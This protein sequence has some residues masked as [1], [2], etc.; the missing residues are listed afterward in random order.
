M[1]RYRATTFYI[2]DLFN[3]PVHEKESI[4]RRAVYYIRA[5]HAF[6][7]RVSMRFFRKDASVE[8]SKGNIDIGIPVSQY[9]MAETLMGFTGIVFDVMEH[10]LG[11]DSIDNKDK[12]K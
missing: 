3:Y 12:E 4:G 9:D 1:K 11:F 7:R 10:M 8:M 6:A 5:M 2:L